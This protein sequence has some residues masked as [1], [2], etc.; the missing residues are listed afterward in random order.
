M[1]SMIKFSILFLV[2]G[3]CLPDKPKEENEEETST[4]SVPTESM[5]VADTSGDPVCGPNMVTFLSRVR[6]QEAS[7]LAPE[8]CRSEI[9]RSGCMNGEQSPYTGTFKFETCRV[10]P[11]VVEPLNCGNLNHGQSENRTLSTP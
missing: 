6:Y 2:L 1:K 5:P 4:V 8:V 11:Q 10:I 7:V 9:Q 3:G